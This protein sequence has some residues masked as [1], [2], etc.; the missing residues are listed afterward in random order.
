MSLWISLSQR[1][2]TKILLINYNIVFGDIHSC[3]QYNWQTAIWHGCELVPCKIYKG[4]KKK[5]NEEAN[6]ETVSKQHEKFS[7]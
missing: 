3:N 6:L 7:Q 5:L 1:K 2:I 4:M